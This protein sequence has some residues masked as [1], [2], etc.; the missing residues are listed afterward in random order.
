MS[1]T[2]STKVLKRRMLLLGCIASG[3]IQMPMI[4]L[5]WDMRVFEQSL[6]KLHRAK[7]SC[8][9]LGGTAISLRQVF[10]VVAQEVVAELAFWHSRLRGRVGRECLS[11]RCLAA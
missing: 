7:A 5:A 9:L 6:A 11:A 1:P 3:L 4:T 10:A 8:D 2:L